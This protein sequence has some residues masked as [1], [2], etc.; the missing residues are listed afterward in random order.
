MAELTSQPAEPPAVKKLKQSCYFDKKMDH[1][2]NNK[3][4][5]RHCTATC[6]VC[7]TF[8][9]KN[10]AVL[11]GWQWWLP[12]V[13][14]HQHHP[15]HTMK[16]T[17]ISIDNK[18]TE[19]DL[20][21]LAKEGNCLQDVHMAVAG[22]LLK[23]FPTRA[24]FQPTVCEGSAATRWRDHPIPFRQPAKTLDNIYTQQGYNLGLYPG[25]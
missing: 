7:H 10:Q 2:N 21:Y 24:G 8:R 6:M 18:L 19:S 23:Q 9:E 25:S 5:Y 16:I 1:E 15:H 12:T 17:Q 22:E 14:A 13:A 3:L 4:L 20:A 11:S